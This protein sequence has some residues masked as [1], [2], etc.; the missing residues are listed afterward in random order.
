MQD[1]LRAIEARYEELNEQMAQPEVVADYQRL[2]ELAI[3]RSAID[4]VVSLY[5]TLR[6]TEGQIEEARQLTEDGS[7]P[8]F[9]RLAREELQS[10]EPER[11]RLEDEL[12][13]ALLPTDPHDARDVIVEIRAGTGGE[14]AAF[15]A[16]DLF[17]M[18]SRYAESRNWQVEV[19]STSE[20]EK[21]GFKEIV[22]EV[23]GRGAYSR[24]KFESGGHRV[25]RVPATEASGRVHTSTSTVVVLP[26]AEEV[27]VD[28]DEKDLRI[29]IYH[30]GGA[31]GQ[32][33]N[34]VATA[35]RITHLPTNIVVQCQDERSQLKNRVK[36]MS[37]LRARLLQ[38]KEQAQAAEISDSRKSQAGTGERA[39]KIRTYNFSQDRITDH[40]VGYTRHGMS[41]FLDGDIDDVV[42]AVAT[43]DQAQ[44]LEE[45]LV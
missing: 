28:I 22:F 34:K 38:V 44:R 6:D 4:K 32:N 16:S 3:E 7:D 30:S 25:Q 36:A 24:L 35:V 40:R 1:K 29:D 19:M 26:E 41:V 45:A 10:L 12:K 20:S 31:G 23:H 8:E 42:D 33:V 11:D 2:Q 21:G 15:F 43:A 39:E 27:E 17:R 14:E 5:R 37:V 18:Y 13:L 9:A